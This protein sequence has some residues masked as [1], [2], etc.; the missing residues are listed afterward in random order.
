MTGNMW[1]A[2][3]VGTTILIALLSISWR[4]SARLTH[5]EDKQDTQGNDIA[6][7][8]Q[9]VKDLSEKFDNIPKCPPCAIDSPPVPT[10]RRRRAG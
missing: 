6:D 5:I 2:L 8:K 10:G 9:D 4:G 7:V 1:A 3:G